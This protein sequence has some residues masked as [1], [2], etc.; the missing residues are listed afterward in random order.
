MTKLKAVLILLLTIS[1]T[2]AEKFDPA[3]WQAELKANQEKLIASYVE[4]A[5]M[6]KICTTKALK[7]ELNMRDDE[8]AK[9]TL[10][11][12]RRRLHLYCDPILD[13]QK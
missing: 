7:Y 8:L 6:C 4:N 13:S 1:L 3:K 12:Y 2:H 10:H 9:A 5:R 11:N